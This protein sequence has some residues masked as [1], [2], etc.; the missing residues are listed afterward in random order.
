MDKTTWTFK[1]NDTTST[2]SGTYG[3]LS[4][5]RYKIVTI[6]K[7]D[8][9]F[10]VYKIYTDDGGFEYF[11][12]PQKTTHRKSPQSYMD[13]LIE[14]SVRSN[15]ISTMKDQPSVRITRQMMLDNDITNYVD[16]CCFYEDYSAIGTGLTRDIR[17][18]IVMDIDVDCEQ[19]DNKKELDDLLV[20]FS[21]YDFL[22]DFYILNHETNHVQLQWLVKNV[23]YKE[24]DID[25]YKSK[26]SSLESDTDKSKEINLYGT[27]FTRLTRGGLD[28]RRFTRVLTYLV[29]KHKFG[30]RNYTFWKA[31][32]FYTALMRKYNLELKMPYKTKSGIK[33]FTQDEMI[34]K[35]Q[36]KESR[37][38]Y[39]NKSYTINEIYK[40]T[41]DLLK[42]C[43]TQV[44]DTKIQSVVDE[45]DIKPTN[46]KHKHIY[47]KSRN[48]FVLSC[49]RE[50]TWEM[51]RQIGIK[52][53]EE[54]NEMKQYK[55]KKF[56]SDVK[57]KVREKFEQENEKYG[58]VWPGTSDSSSIYT[59]GEFNSTF[60]SSFNFATQK[61]NDSC[62]TDT[63]REQSLQSRNF[64]K[65]LNLMVVDFVKSQYSIR[66]GRDLMMTKIN[67]I[68]KNSG[69]SEISLSSL[70]RYISELKGM[71]NENKKEHFVTLIEE[72]EERQSQLR[73]S[74]YKRGEIDKTTNIQRKRNQY[75]QLSEDVIEY[76]KEIYGYV[77][78]R[79]L[80]INGNEK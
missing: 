25:T 53:S 37:Y 2:L 12:D 21:E 47:G 29:P 55:I 65:T 43:I 63:Q 77:S 27:D 71:T 33:F 11:V 34:S 36:T 26:L 20:K 9:F 10:V 62:Y 56:K 54:F 22:P 39:F 1:V 14:Y 49:T 50:T 60:N 46:T 69:Q 15:D 16:M 59:T 42:D 73:F 68:L 64:K 48:E 75:L 67:T 32:N 66:L 41:Q 80:P 38:Y 4:D 17:N 57:K 74:I 45:C 58:G 72:I 40:K 13:S 31:K 8:H 61:L 28:Y 51:A 23:K 18:I 5:Y 24:I 79:Y 78:K 3:K 70:K 30:D 6:R 35:F 44:D 52:T 7:D 19:E 76:Y